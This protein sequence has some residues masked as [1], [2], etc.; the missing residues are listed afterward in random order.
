MMRRGNR[1]ALALT[2][3]TTV[4]LIGSGCASEVNQPAQPDKSAAETPAAENSCPDGIETAIQQ[5]WW[6][7][8]TDVSAANY[9]VTVQPDTAFIEGVPE[10]FFDDVAGA[11]VV[12]TY[13][14]QLESTQA[15]VLFPITSEDEV[16]V[17]GQK[18]LD[19][20]WSHESTQYI[21]DVEDPESVGAFV[22]AIAP[23][24]A[25]RFGFSSGITL[26]VIQVGRWSDS[27]AF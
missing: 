27:G 15:L 2:V 5:A 11:C 25:P 26:G 18:L 22:A 14:S 9:V 6:N 3:A 21:S 23:E 24:E 12:D 17:F 7:N 16:E 13:S 1:L 4:A 19:A 20:G 8:Q 10:G